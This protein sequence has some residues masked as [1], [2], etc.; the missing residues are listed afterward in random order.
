[1]RL[2]DCLEKILKH[3]NL[4][5]FI[6]FV[7]IASLVFGL[8]YFTKFQ[9]ILS[10]AVPT[11]WSGAPEANAWSIAGESYAFSLKVALLLSAAIL[12]LCFLLEKVFYKKLDGI[13]IRPFTLGVISSLVL[14]FFTASLNEAT[15]ASRL[16]GGVLTN[17]ALGKLYA[18]LAL[19]GFFALLSLIV[20]IASLLSDKQSLN[21]SG[22]NK[23]SQWRTFYKAKRA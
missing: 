21:L 4:A 11:H 12:L 16:N 17:S 7:A 3:Q 6:A 8:Q 14:V 23:K 10:E 15:C 20:S 18:L 22:K 2:K 9:P 5:S 13:K 19:I 1:M